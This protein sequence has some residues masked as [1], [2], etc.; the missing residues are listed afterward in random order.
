MTVMSAPVDFA[1]APEDVAFKDELEAFLDKEMPP[2]IEQWSANEDP[3]A[4]DS[5]ARTPM[6]RA[7]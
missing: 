2:F 3:D 4:R 6:R 1:W 7:A 5:N